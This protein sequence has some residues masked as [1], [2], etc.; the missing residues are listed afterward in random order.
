[1]DHE[2]LTGV[3]I[4]AAIEVHRELGP[5]F[6][7]VIYE[8]ALQVELRRLRLSFKSQLDVPI[9]YRGVQVG[10]HRLDLLVDDLI[11]IELKSVKAIE[12]V[13]FAIVR[14][15]LH[16]VDRNDGLILNFAKPKLEIRRVLGPQLNP[17]LLPTPPPPG[18]PASS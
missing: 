14:S 3:I 9:F 15:Y 6:L 1:M 10:L 11:V 2:Q 4:G 5:G 7:E 18:F 12:D 13:H 17:R 8:H 16:A